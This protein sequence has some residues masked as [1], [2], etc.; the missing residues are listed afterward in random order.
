MFTQ[1]KE[2]YFA[3]LQ[4]GKSK[5]E[6]PPKIIIMA[7]CAAHITL[8][9]AVDGSSGTPNKV[10]APATANGYRP[11]PPFVAAIL[12]PPAINPTKIPPNGTSNP[13]MAGM[14]AQN[15][16]IYMTQINTV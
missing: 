6:R 9:N 5:K 10:N 11:I 7:V 15:I 3:L 8:P 13:L 12:N 2:N 14:V 16:K 4:I 1:R